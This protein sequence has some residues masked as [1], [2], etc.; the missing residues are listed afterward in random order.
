MKASDK[1]T[2]L[3]LANERKEK[4]AAAQSEDSNE[5]ELRKNLD[6]VIEWLEKGVA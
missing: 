1:A 4:M 6:K 3:D 2:A 5:L